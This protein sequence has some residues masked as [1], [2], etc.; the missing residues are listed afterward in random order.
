MRLESALTSQTDRYERFYEGWRRLE[1]I[2]RFDVRYRCRRMQEVLTALQIPTDG[3][4]VLDV[5]FGWGHMLL[6]FPTSCHLSGADISP[7]A[8]ATASRNAQFTPYAGTSFHAVRENVLSDLPPGPFDVIVCSHVLEHVPDDQAL[9]QHLH[10]RLAPG[11]VVVVFVPIEPPDYSLIHLRAYSLQSISER[12]IQSG[13][14]LLHSEG[15]MYVEGHIWRLLTIPTRREW[16][17]VGL[18]TSGVRLGLFSLVPYRL[19]HAA[20]RM[21]FRLG[22]SACQALVVGRTPTDH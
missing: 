13:F 7:S 10:A 22:F 21:L 14:E 12:V 19:L 18:A 9:L 4:R 8:I 20:D 11:G 3:A 1:G 15:S 5:G 16:P 2:L 6:T 17:L